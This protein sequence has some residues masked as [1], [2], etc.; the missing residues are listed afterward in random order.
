M[1]HLYVDTVVFMFCI[2]LVSR[3]S[4]LRSATVRRRV[5]HNAVHQHTTN[6]SL[7]PDQFTAAMMKFAMAS[8]LLVVAKAQRPGPNSGYVS[9]PKTEF[10][11]HFARAAVASPAAQRALAAVVLTKHLF[12]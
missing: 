12:R 9:A 6:S 3:G 2:N 8:A 1:Y 4:L 5:R 7:R 11:D 10:A